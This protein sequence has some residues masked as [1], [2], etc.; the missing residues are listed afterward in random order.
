[1]TPHHF[2]LLLRLNLFS[3]SLFVCLPAAS[4]GK[5][6]FAFV[7]HGGPGNPFWNVVHKGMEDAADR[8]GVD[9]QWLS[10]TTFSIKD[11]AKA[12]LWMML[13]AAVCVTAVAAVMGAVPFGGL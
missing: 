6:K 12:G 4:A 8:Y 10:N 1:M 2:T 5:Y 11:M 13:G 3:L 7:V 9:V